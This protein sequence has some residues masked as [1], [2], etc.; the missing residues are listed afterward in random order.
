VYD[1]TNINLYLNGVRVLQT[2][3][4]NTNVSASIL[5]GNST[6]SEQ[7]GGYISNLRIIKGVKTT[8]AILEGHLIVLQT[9]GSTSPHCSPNT[10][11]VNISFASSSTSLLTCQNSTFIDNSS[12]SFTI[13]STGST[14]Y[15]IKFFNN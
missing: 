12:N 8:Q 14:Q 2:A 1:G 3:M 10:T 11:N 13:T 9:S 6:Y 15:S 7:F 4:S 5:I